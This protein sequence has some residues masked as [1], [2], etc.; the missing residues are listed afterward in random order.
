MLLFSVRTSFQR[1]TKLQT[2]LH[3]H[4]FTGRSVAVCFLVIFYTPRLKK[5]RQKE[6]IGT[7]TESPVLLSLCRFISSLIFRCEILHIS[8]MGDNE[9]TWD[10]ITFQ[11]RHFH[12]A[13]ITPTGGLLID[14][15]CPKYH[16]GTNGFPPSQGKQWNEHRF[17]QPRVIDLMTKSFSLRFMGEEER[18]M[19]NKIGL[20]G[21]VF[22]REPSCKQERRFYLLWFHCIWW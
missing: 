9:T 8:V 21:D 14:D 4:D 1:K 15:A 10:L 12:A 2:K 16:S 5:T 7:S 11:H 18:H 17:N 22:V 13:I 6:I 3:K 19:Q 20:G